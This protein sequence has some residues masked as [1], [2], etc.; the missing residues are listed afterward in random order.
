MNIAAADARASNVTRREYWLD[1]LDAWRGITVEQLVGAALL[2]LVAGIP[3]TNTLVRNFGLDRAWPD[4]FHLIAGTL[5]T[6]GCVLLA[7]VVADRRVDRGARRTS[8]YAWAL[9]IGVV[10][11]AVLHGLFVVFIVVPGDERGAL[12]ALWK[13][14]PHSR[15]T[16][17]ALSIFDWLAIGSLAIYL[18]ADRRDSQKILANLQAAQ[19]QQSTRERQ[20]LESQLQALQARV[21]PQFLFNTLARIRKLYDDDAALGDQMLDDL[22]VYLRAAMPRMRD[23]S[24]TL[25]QE[26]ELAHAYLNIL[27]RGVA[28]RLDFAAD[29]PE[30]LGSARFPPMMLLPLIDH[31]I[32][33]NLDRPKIEG[34]LRIAGEISGTR[35]RIAIID[36][37]AGFAPEA[38]G[39]GVANIRERLA[40]LYG[41]DASLVLRQR[42]GD[43]TEAMMEIPYEA[44]Q[45]DD[46]G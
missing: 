39:N 12:A 3:P 23:S 5:F 46:G 8:A 20:V 44:V 10:I 9:L 6:A 36:S 27:K 2:G 41:E 35:L 1:A 29:V 25:A 7:V 33:R 37:A 34:G 30:G 45:E 31:A 17:V 38:T 40:A 16:I 43:S 18:Y 28:D 14:S 21:E 42:G 26:I 22:I 19:V 13:A 32:V 11:G 15:Y 24:S 4:A